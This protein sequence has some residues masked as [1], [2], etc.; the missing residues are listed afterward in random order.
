[1][2]ETCLELQGSVSFSS[3][4]PAAVSALDS[5]HTRASVACRH[6]A[7]GTRCSCGCHVRSATH[8]SS[9]SAAYN[10][11]RALLPSA[12]QHLMQEHMAGRHTRPLLH[13]QLSSMH[14]FSKQQRTYSS[15]RKWAGDDADD[16]FERSLDFHSP[17]STAQ[18]VQ[19][20]VWR[21]DG[22]TTVAK[23]LAI[24]CYGKA[25]G[26]LTRSLEGLGCARL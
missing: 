16:E 21:V 25:Q 17:I 12:Q 26:C 19:V 7:S 15:G 18:A 4:I 10:L 2:I 13:Q 14:C 5:P 22:C 20:C 24:G 6:S 11:A 23:A 3:E 1:M 9:S 8:S